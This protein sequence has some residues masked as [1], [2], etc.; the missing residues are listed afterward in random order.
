MPSKNAF[1]PCLRCPACHAGER[2]AYTPTPATSD[3]SAEVAAYLA[4]Y[5][6]SGPT[7]GA[8]DQGR[9]EQKRKLQSVGD[10]IAAT[11]AAAE[12][13]LEG[14]SGQEA[15]ANAAERALRAGEVLRLGGRGCRE[16]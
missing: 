5:G 1:K 6:V 9:N 13:A 2:L 15:A 12:A 11:R 14:S 7:P 10:L 3:S 8:Q 16:A 4:R